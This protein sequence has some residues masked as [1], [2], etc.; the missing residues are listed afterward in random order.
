MASALITQLH[1]LLGPWGAKRECIVKIFWTVGYKT[2]RVMVFEKNFL[3][4]FKIFC[5]A[6]IQNVPFDSEVIGTV[7]DHGP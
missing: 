1:F 5:D 7:I 6:E 3:T 2:S 4:F